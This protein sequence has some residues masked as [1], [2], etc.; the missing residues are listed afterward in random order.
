MFK[1][2]NSYASGFAVQMLSQKVVDNGIWG[3]NNVFFFIHKMEM[4]FRWQY[5][6]W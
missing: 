1:I 3:E 4:K 6:P 2:N 5:L